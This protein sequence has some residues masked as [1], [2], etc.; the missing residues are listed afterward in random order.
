VPQAQGD[1]ADPEGAFRA[2]LDGGFVSK[3]H[4]ILGLAMVLGSQAFADA[5]AKEIFGRGEQM[6]SEKKWKDAGEQFQK[7]IDLEKNYA[8]AWNHLGECLYNQGDIFAAIEKFKNAIEINPRYTSALYNLGMGFENINNE[9]RIKGDDK[10]IKKLAKTQFQQAVEAYR[11]AL[12]ILPVN[13][14]LAVANSHYRLGTVLRDLEESKDPKDQNYKEAIAQLEAA[15]AMIP[16]FPECRNELGR[17]Y[18]IIGR[19]PEA[20]DQY[21][22]AIQGHKYY[23]QAYSNRGVAWWHD[24]NW[25]NAL[26]DCRQAVEID[27]RFAGGHYN[28]AEV[29]FA[30]VQVLTANGDSAVVHEE[31]EKAIDEYTAA[32]VLDPSFK[33][34]WLGLGRAYWAYH[35]YD[36]AQATY[37]KVLEMDKKDKT[38]KQ[39]I[40]D[41]KAEQKTYVSHIPKA[42]Q[43]GQQAK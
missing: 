3:I 16:D 21:T 15:I 40:K 8:E 27:P 39:A 12:N 41:M 29:V 23:A 36:K 5:D 14:E 42:Y 35:D 38:A 7:A 18:D 10:T 37:T 19:Y 4:L 22:K 32:T 30:R 26:A 33:G 43:E 25:D 17:T 28:F 9:K 24:G 13:D 6:L 34:A 31:V 20:I 1:P 2:S 11:K